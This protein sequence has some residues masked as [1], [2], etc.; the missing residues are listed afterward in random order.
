[1]K[2][3]LLSIFLVTALFAGFQNCSQ[4]HFSPE[5]LID[6]NLKSNANGTG[7]GGKPD[8]DFYRFHPQFTCEN[9]SVPVSEIHITATE[10]TY[11]ENQ[12]LQ[13]GAIKQTLDPNSID[14]SVF[15]N[16]V[17]G[18]KDGIFESQD[19]TPLSIPANLVEVWCRTAKDKSG[20]ET[21][22]HFNRN[23]SQADT[24]I[25]YASPTAPMKKTFV[26]SRVVSAQKVTVTD[27]NGLLIEVY[28]DKPAVEF[29]LFQGSMQAVIDGNKITLPTSCRLGG[30]FDSKIWPAQ[31]V[32]DSDVQMFKMAPDLSFFGYTAK[33]GAE[34][35][36][37]FASDALG[38][39]HRTVSPPMLSVGVSNFEFT[40]GSNSF[41]YWGDPRYVKGIE[42]FRVNRDGSNHFQL[43]QPVT[44]SLQGQETDIQFSADGSRVFYRDG[45]QETG[46]EG[47]ADIEMWLRSVPLI[48]G[49]PT[50]INPPLPLGGD[51][52]V[53]KFAISK[54]QNKVAYLAGNI[55]PSL[56]IADLDGKHTV[57]ML[58]ATEFDWTETVRIPE[59]GDYMFI[60]TRDQISM[61]IMHFLT[62]VV[63]VDGSGSKALPLD[64][65]L[66]SVHPHGQTALIFNPR[67]D[68]RFSDQSYDKMKLMDLQSGTL[69]N[70]PDLNH[71]FFS[72]DAMSLIG[73][74][75]DG[76]GAVQM[77]RISMKDQTE[78]ELC[79]VVQGRELFVKELGDEVYFISAYD[80]FLKILS[81]YMR[82]ADGSC[83]QK[84][85]IP[86]TSPNLQDVVISP[87]QKKILVKASIVQD[88]ISSD[89]I[90]YIPLNGEAPL[91][92]NT[93]LFIGAKISSFQFLQDSRTILYVGD[94]LT[95]GQKG[96]FVWRAP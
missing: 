43:N 96:V 71:P 75:S 1:M 91:T 51:V 30:S 90:Y 29:G 59:P 11:I 20:I 13:C 85:S 80:S 69:T 56:Y 24:E 41:V 34:P 18:W 2:K 21:I 93:A 6:D 74:K 49:S 92:V 15:Q 83:A 95:P 10:T 16:D 65:E 79:S 77:V 42:L 22:T 76:S 87:D 64:W 89:Q 7:Y 62:H 86:V 55:S 82:Q 58:A 88:N 35:A 60:Q 40:P 61:G 38:S 36:R 72:K 66:H 70:L 48:G 46:P 26:V 25:Y 78:S 50:V 47:G 84:N 4:V 14:S 5:Q 68:I 44:N 67:S 31:Q 33:I 12:K 73:A 28:R 52:G 63:A 9:N 27:G 94:Q 45:Q 81:F 37:L 23:T 19:S 54:S 8:G 17:V 57:Q 53:Y 3:K 39:N 32:V